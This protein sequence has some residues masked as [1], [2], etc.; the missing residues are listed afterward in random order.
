M[1]RGFGRTLDVFL[2]LVV[3]VLSIGVFA[4]LSLPEPPATP[5]P[6]ETA[7][8]TP[9]PS[10]TAPATL[11]P[12]PTLGPSLTPSP[13]PTFTP[14]P[15]PTAAATAT[16]TGPQPTAPP[17]STA[18]PLPLA[19]RNAV[20]PHSALFIR[21]HNDFSQA[22]TAGIENLVAEGL[23]IADTDI[24]FGAFDPLG[25]A[26]VAD[27]T[28]ANALALHFGLVPIPLSQKRDP[29]AT[30]YLEIALKAA[31]GA[32]GPAAEAAGPAANYVFV[33]D[34]SGSMEGAKLAGAEAGIRALFAEMRPQDTIGIVDFDSQ[35]RIALPATRVADLGPAALNAA[36]RRLVAQGGTDLDLGLQA[37][38]REAANFAGGSAVSHVFLF[39]DGNPTDRV[40][41]WLEIRA[42]A[43]TALR[44]IPVR[45][46][47]FAFGEDANGRELDALAGVAGG[48]YTSVVDPATLGHDLAI[49]L[50]RRDILV[51][52]DVRLTLNIDPSVS[53]L[54]LYGH[55]RVE[56]PIA[57]AALDQ[58]PGTDI[59]AVDASD[60]EEGLRIYVPDLAAGE[61]YWVVFEVAI[62]ETSD[63]AIGNGS[64]SYVDPPTGEILEAHAPL[65]LSPSPIK[66]APDLVIRHALGLWTSDTVLYAVDDL[67]Q[68]DLETTA[69]RLA[70]YTAKLEGAYADLKTVWL[71]DDATTMHELAFL[72]DSLAE[73]DVSGHAADD[74]RSLLLYEL[75]ALGRARDGFT[76][77]DAPSSP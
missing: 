11:R 53:I 29:R 44:D 31:P 26:R 36:L 6:T 64:V 49:E 4:M 19:P 70:D 38:I 52:K 28:G 20:L 15:S 10:P 47:T 71:A 42:N 76:R 48:T 24:T 74:A 34:T 40:T 58:S 59:G 21:R 17:G 22:A 68:N 7:T 30:H 25:G 73:G 35:T 55:D 56:E 5:K 54:Y 2:L 27:P 61:A 14:G 1:F 37:G 63:G 77:V 51:G 32:T 66:L 12:V 23:T 60:A 45:V 75:N 16:P 57:R 67:A 65:T 72:A 43:V 13:T 69:A 46:S 33:V 9:S 8:A 39:S 3:L 18:T 62:P 41:D 50:A